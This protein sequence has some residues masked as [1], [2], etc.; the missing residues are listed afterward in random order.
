MLRLTEPTF[1]FN[2]STHEGGGVE[3]RGGG[4]GTGR[5]SSC[6]W[7]VFTSTCVLNASDEFLCGCGASSRHVASRH[8]TCFLADTDQ[9]YMYSVIS[10]RCIS[11]ELVSD[12]R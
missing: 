4:E 7:N 8:V 5:S 3:E 2:K 12:R 10:I 9:Q 11:D 1:L 6:Q